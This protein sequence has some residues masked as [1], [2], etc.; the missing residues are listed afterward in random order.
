MNKNTSFSK[1][2]S[3]SNLAV[4]ELDDISL[5]G[6]FSHC[7]IGIGNKLSPERL[8]FLAVEYKFKH[9]LQHSAI[10]HDKQLHIS[11]SMLENPEDFFKFPLCT[12]FNSE[13]KN[14]SSEKALKALNIKFKNSAEKN[15]AL[16]SLVECLSS[17]SKDQSLILDAKLVAD[18]LMCN[19]L[20][21]APPPKIKKTLKVAKSGTKTKT[22]IKKD[23]KERVIKQAKIFVGATE[24][25]III[26]CEDTYGTLDV[27]KLL[28]R[29]RD[30]FK[31][32]DGAGIA[33][34][35]NKGAGLGTY[36][37]F[38]VCNSMYFAVDKDLRTIVCC[39]IPRLH[40]MRN[41]VA[42]SKTLHLI[43]PR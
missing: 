40:K 36:I 21:N 34:L 29:V 31:R 33:N 1:T 24:S 12:I 19:A 43:V 22:K 10:D 11:K 3:K 42:L 8:L 41:K 20:Y 14:S 28:G 38:S 15:S 39:S 27:I 17:L 25:E 2:K 37:V 35:G 5:D 7:E 30:C 18:E 4:V 9:L 32:T 23:E 26:G 6:N 13:N 16:D